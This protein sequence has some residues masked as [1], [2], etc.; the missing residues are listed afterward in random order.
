[1]A[2]RYSTS[3]SI[4]AGDHLFGFK[5][6]NGT[7]MEFP[8][9]VLVTYLNAALSIS[10][11]LTKQSATPSATGFTVEIDSGNTWLLLAPTAGFATGTITLPDGTD[12]EEVE[13]SCTQL[14][15]TL[16]VDNDDGASIVG[17][18]STLSANDF[19]KMRYD[20]NNDAWYRIG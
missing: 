10:T 18:P 17:A 1:M 4:V 15:T 6:T 8:V 5:T 2:T 7:W 19:F 14:V 12:G 3:D 20:A 9:S 16:T 11:S 13:I